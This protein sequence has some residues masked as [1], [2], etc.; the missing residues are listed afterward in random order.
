MAMDLE[1]RLYQ[2]SNHFYMLSAIDFKLEEPFIQWKW[3]H[4]KGHQDDHIETLDR[5]ATLNVEYDLVEKQV[6]NISGNVSVT[7]PHTQA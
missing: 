6:V 7:Q 4:V 5:R 1:T 2:E 3:C